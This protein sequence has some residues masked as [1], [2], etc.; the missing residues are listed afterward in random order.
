MTRFVGF[1]N[2]VN[3]STAIRFIALVLPVVSQSPQEKTLRQWLCALRPLL[4][5]TGPAWAANDSSSST[6][7]TPAR[8]I[9]MISLFLHPV[10]PVILS[11]K[12]VRRQNHQTLAA[13]RLRYFLPYTS[14][15]MQ[16]G[17]RRPL[18]MARRFSAAITAIRVR[19]ATVALPMCG[20]RTALSI[21]ASPGC[22]RG[23]FS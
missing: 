9:C 15:L 4:A 12:N 3:P 22:S 1:C 6:G 17:A 23:S 5:S 19:V 13:D 20:T 11:N 18:T 16:L 10:H 14:G 21:P 7:R 8:L 2:R